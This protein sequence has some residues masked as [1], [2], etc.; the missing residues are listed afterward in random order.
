MTGQCL[1]S[2][3]RDRRRRSELLLPR[4]LTSETQRTTE[5]NR[6][7]SLVLWMRWKVGHSQCRLT[8][9]FRVFTAVPEEP[10]TKLVPVWGSQVQTADA[11]FAGLLSG[12][13]RAEPGRA[14]V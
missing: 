14:W 4:G 2:L 12:G 1:Y 9:Q 11:L 5:V 6:P 8:Q 7:I 3:Q 10:G 13:G